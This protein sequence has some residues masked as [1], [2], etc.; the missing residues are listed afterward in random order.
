MT[1]RLQHHV[2]HVHYVDTTMPPEALQMVEEQLQWLTPAAMVSKVQFSYPQ[3]TAPQIHTAWREMSQV[4]WRRND[5][6]LPSAMEL[7]A[8]HSNDVDIF[9]LADIPEGV[10]MLAW[11]MKRIAG[12][13]KG[14][15]IEIGMD[16]TCASPNSNIA[17]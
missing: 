8:E 11:G 9:K 13:L 4:Y 15:V 14:K 2:K 12:P 7:L 5:L 1:V 16:A 10:E 3:V 17:W 6:Q